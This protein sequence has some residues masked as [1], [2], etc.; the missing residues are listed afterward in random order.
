M[1]QTDSPTWQH[2]ISQELDQPDLPSL[3]IS[4]TKCLRALAYAYQG[5]PFSDPPDEHSRNR[6]AMGHMAEVLI[7]KNLQERGWETG[8]TVLPETGQLEVQVQV[9]GSDV[10]MKGHP[11]GICRHPNFTKN[12]WITLE[13]KSMSVSWALEVEQKG[14]FEVYPH[15]LTQI[16]LYTRRMYEMGLVSHQEKG[17]FAMMDRDGRPLSPERVSWKPATVDTVLR[18]LAE[19]LLQ[20]DSGELP[21][22]PFPA[23]SMECNFCPVHGLCRG[24]RVEW[25]E[26]AN[27]QPAR[28]NTED[29]E[30]IAAG[31]EWQKLKPKWDRVKNVF[32]EASDQAGKV[33]IVAGPVTGGYFQPKHRP[34][35]DLTQLT[36]LVP[37]DILRKC[38]VPRQDRREGFWMRSTNR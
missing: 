16:S 11:D 31:K 28:I 19:V 1:I 26:P 7:I 34:A 8:H 15:Y 35:Y 27:G 23:G 32:Q 4:A 14:V 6:M 29:Q 24:P 13:A 2:L 20:T 21:D 38:L 5:I 25:D 37:A 22:R 18:Q 12:R 17:L 30:I 10:T 36:R 9:P 3:R 33:D